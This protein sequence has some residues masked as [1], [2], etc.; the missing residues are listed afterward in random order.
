MDKLAKGREEYFKKLRSGEIIRQNPI[1]KAKANPS[2][3][4]LAIE[5]KCW[6]CC[7]FQRKEVTLCEIEDCPLWTFRPWQG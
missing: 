5:A 4:K 3:R 1:E 6:D 2:S 7:C